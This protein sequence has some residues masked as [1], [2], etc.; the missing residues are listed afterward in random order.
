MPNAE[1]LVNVGVKLDKNSLESLKKQITDADIKP[2]EID[3]KFKSDKVQKEL[4]TLRKD[5]QEILK[6][7]TQISKTGFGSVGKATKGVQSEA[8]RALNF[9]KQ[10]NDYAKKLYSTPVNSNTAQQRRELEKAFSDVWKQYKDIEKKLGG[11]G[12][13]AF[14][15]VRDQLEKTVRDSGIEIGKLYDKINSD[16]LNKFLSKYKDFADLRKRQIN[17]IDDKDIEQARQLEREIAKVKTELKTL[18]ADIGAGGMTADAQAKVK[19]MARSI[20]L[21]QSKAMDKATAKAD[22]Q[23]LK[24]QQEAV[25]AFVSKY[26]ELTALQKQRIN[27]I[28]DE[29]VEQAKLLEREIAKV[30]SELKEMGTSLGA[31]GLTDK[32]RTQVQAMAKSVSLAQAKVI[33]KAN[34]KAE[35][36]AIKKQ[37]DA[38][39]EYLKNRKELN[40]LQLDRIKLVNTEGAVEELKT[41]DKAL[42]RT[43]EKVHRMREELISQYGENVFDPIAN[44]LDEL[45]VKLLRAVKQSTDRVNLKNSNEAIRQQKE[46]IKS[47][48]NEIKR[49]QD[50]VNRA[51]GLQVNGK[52][53][54]EEFKE[55]R[56]QAVEVFENVEQM[57]RALT[58]SYGDSVFDD[59][60]QELAEF[61]RKMDIALAKQKDGM[62]NNLFKKQ[63]EGLREYKKAFS[64]M[65]DYQIKA[66]KAYQVGDEEKG[67]R[68]WT[69]ANNLKFSLKS[70]A[71]EMGQEFGKDFLAPIQSEILK[72]TNKLADFRVDSRNADVMK[73]QNKALEQYKKNVQQILALKKERL[74]LVDANDADGV[75]KVDT[76]IH[77]LIGSCKELR[78]A[79]PD[80]MMDGVANSWKSALGNLNKEIS[81]RQKAITKMNEEYQRITSDTAKSERSTGMTNLEARWNKLSES[82][83]GSSKAL[84]EARRAQ[85]NL[86]KAIKSGDITKTIQAYK[87]YQE[88][89]K[90]TDSAIRQMEIHQRA[91]NDEQALNKRRDTL[92]QNIDKWLSYNSGA[93]EKFKNQ[94][95]DI[96]RQLKSVDA[97][98]LNH[99]EAEFRRLDTQAEMAGQK[100]MSFGDRL[101][102]QVARFGAYLS[103][104]QAIMAVGRG[105]RE[106][107]ENVKNLDSAM[108][109]L[110]K[111]TDE[112]DST[113]ANFLQSAKSR[114]V[115]LSTTMT[116]FINSTADFARLGYSFTEAQDLASVASKYNVVGDN[117]ESID[118]ATGHLISTMRAFQMESSDAISIVDKLNEVS[119]NFAVT[120]G[121]LGSGLEVA[122]SALATAGNDLDQTIALITGGTEI[123]QDANST[124]RGIRTI[125]LRIRGMD[126][127]LEELGEDTD[128]MIKYTPKLRKE[129]QDMAGVDIM[130]GTG[131][132]LRD[133]YDIL[134][135]LAHRWKDLNDVQRA[136][137]T[138]SLAGKNRANVFNAL[139]TNWSQVESAYETAKNSAGSADAEFERYQDSI[140]AKLNQL[141]ASL[142]GLS[143]SVLDSEFLKG[144]IDGLRK[145]VEVIDFV[146]D[147]IG[148]FPILLSGAFTAWS[149]KNSKEIWN[150]I[151]NS[152]LSAGAESGVKYTGLFK[153]ALN[154]LSDG[155]WFVDLERGAEASG[156]KSA[157]GFKNKFSRR[158]S[159]FGRMF[160]NLTFGKTNLLS[161][162]ASQSFSAIGNIQDIFSK[163]QSGAIDS[164]K[165]IAGVSKE[166]SRLSSTAV[167]A[168][169]NCDVHLES[170]KNS[171][172]DGGDSAKEMARSIQ[173]GFDSYR[174]T[175]ISN[176]A[177]QRNLSSLKALV[178]EFNG[179]TNQFGLSQIELGKK[180]SQS[181]GSV[182]K[183]MIDV[184]KSSDQTTISFGKIAMSE[185]K[186]K[187]ETVALK[188]AFITLQ[189]IGMMA[190]MSLASMAFSKIMEVVQYSKNQRAEARDTAKDVADSLTSV[191]SAYQEFI[192]VRYAYKEGTASKE[193]LTNASNT[194]SD[195]LGLEK[196]QV[197]SLIDEYDTLDNGLQKVMEGSRG[198]ATSISESR[199]QIEAGVNAL[200]K[201]INKAELYNFGL[202]YDQKRMSNFSKDIG[203][204]IDKSKT[205]QKLVSQG[206]MFDTKDMNFLGLGD[207]RKSNAD[208]IIKRYEDAIKLITTYDAMSEKDKK[209]YKGDY[210]ASL[211]YI[212]KAKDGYDE[213]N[214]LKQASLDMDLDESFGKGI[215]KGLPKTQKEFDDLRKS[216]ISVVQADENFTFSQEDATYAVDAFLGSISSMTNYLEASEL[217]YEGL[218]ANID[219]VKE[220]IDALNTA[221][222][223]SV[224]GSGLTTESIDKIGTAFSNLESYNPEKLFERTA[225]GI[226]LN[227]DELERLQKEASEV[228]IKE[229][230]SDLI[231]MARLKEEANRSG[232]KEAY[233]WYDQQISKC[234]DLIAQYDGLTSAYSKWKQAMSSANEG[235]MYEDISS[236]LENIKELRD[237]GLVGTDDFRTFVEFM[238]DTTNKTTKELVDMFDKGYEKMKRFFDGSY[239]GVEDFAKALQNAN[240]EWAHFGKDG[241]EIDLSN[242]KLEDVSA[243]LAEQ[244]VYMSEEAIQIMERRMSDYAWKVDLD[245]GLSGNSDKELENYIDIID[246]YKKAVEGISDL[247]DINKT[248]F[249]NVD[250]NDTSRKI[251]WTAEALEKYKT[252]LG[253][254]GITMKEGDISTVLGMSGDFKGV[255]IAFTP[256]LKTDSGMELL[257]SST[258]NKYINSL[259][260]KAK[261]NSKNGNWTTEDLLALDAKGLEVDG[262]KVQ[263]LIADVGDTAKKTGEAMHYLGTNGELALAEKDARELAKAL[264]MTVEELM[265]VYDGS[266][267]LENL[268]A[269]AKTAKQAVKELGEEPV[270]V[271]TS[272]E[273]IKSLKE[274]LDEAKKKAK[275]LRDDSTIEPDVKDA[276]LKA[277]E[278]D[279]AILVAKI[280]DSNPILSVDVSTVD[281]DVR[282]AFE[283][284]QAYVKAM[285]E[286]DVQVAIGADT[287][288][289]KKKL[290]ETKKALSELTDDQIKKLGLEITVN[291][292]EK[293]VE[294]KKELDEILKKDNSTITVKTNIETQEHTG[295]QKMDELYQEVEV[296]QTPDPMDVNVPDSVPVHLNGILTVPALTTPIKVKLEPANVITPK[297]KTGK[298]KVNYNK[299]GKQVKPKT[300][301]TTVNYSKL[302][303]QAKPKPKETKVSYTKIEKQISPSPKSTKISYTPIKYQE[304]PADKTAKVSYTIT[305]NGVGGSSGTARATPRSTTK[306]TNPTSSSRR[307]SGA[308]MANGTA[309]KS[310]S[311]GARNSGVALMGELGTEL[312][313]SFLR[314][315]R[316]QQCV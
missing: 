234:K 273:G 282:P 62:A 184:A 312:L 32:A 205:Y 252:A 189:S 142:E 90:V 13:T 313:V 138:E 277:L 246:R 35:A 212:N 215:S 204:L 249:G 29:D 208:E 200:T 223:E 265:R 176:I 258:V 100:I 245:V 224:S 45:N 78:T 14:D 186:V 241:W 171:L 119:N 315:Q 67:K 308:T 131:Q 96:Q 1:F 152:A 10:A 43:T 134:G 283:K 239:G 297:V 37:S 120:S 194:L 3:I 124:A 12:S 298:A 53:N 113:Y 34:A 109:E 305:G 267:S 197:R 177:S 63:V 261:K 201:D 146:L 275:E 118:E 236:Q 9:Y 69:L 316:I 57:K 65:I 88:Q 103:V 48:F 61:D 169:G 203:E 254:W 93:S 6:I 98:R 47:Y 240:K 128:G 105:A 274:E 163:F 102:L 77:Q 202:I 175:K 225:N 84:E 243:K 24:E 250:L 270:E 242:V 159:G 20:V 30:K 153:K 148:M 75:Q 262:K 289:A 139:M 149:F 190:I 210:E 122:S 33:D 272:V 301:N 253:S 58:T 106:A 54:T 193:E 231:R 213:L 299:I 76:L 83:R 268:E 123:T 25:N 130:D 111:V 155:N 64:E 125:A 133:T 147:K 19:E 101:K 89:V 82:V 112:T 279:V 17:L 143:E 162:S 285:D 16:K 195:A 227:S 66:E 151:V 168:L 97:T 31:D 196:K 228:K 247:D 311:W 129:L 229:L 7:S 23:A 5:L 136:G 276:K 182:G 46:E 290:D 116:D 185:M 85:E 238:G 259:I 21:E 281:K 44:D 68:Y 117:L 121:D 166:F 27:L 296:K 110:K 222:E 188:G 266:G 91:L 207:E 174:D 50:L 115:D 287:S 11:I 235:A 300:Q 145:F 255:E 191:S 73:D 264:G 36:D 157:E 52:E 256:M 232:D 79:I 132:S 280:N 56:R 214:K 302:G 237:N 306:Y 263:G 137:L 59:Y 292:D 251:E 219:N 309:F 179:K 150:P 140:Q 80:D 291:G 226:S 198:M 28:D 15:G 135:D 51:V 303:K 126:K 307:V 286:Y 8:Q 278:E 4:N 304:P 156:A 107:F 86:D 295:G 104:S 172:K 165:A 158:M 40:A 55:I 95:R 248:V 74:D 22:A 81:D 288:E 38:L 180:V 167:S 269:R 293:V 284:V 71:T 314:S 154:Q 192:N 160:L 220:S 187:A 217:G 92:S 181:W 233:E 257:E 206:K 49:Y 209:K 260:D 211:D 26:K 216:M 114:A 173:T 218:I 42:D 310:G 18:G 294:S 141:K 108:T 230:N 127:E 244:G 60:S 178:D 221:M 170:M 70:M 199:A 72:S 164:E 183:T 99:L 2:L 271:D 144:A 94:M 39:K 87:Q 161:N 41:V